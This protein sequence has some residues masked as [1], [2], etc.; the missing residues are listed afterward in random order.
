MSV[1][2]SSTTAGYPATN[3]VDGSP[4]TSWFSGGGATNSFT[5]TGQRVENLKSIRLRWNEFNPDFPH[6][7]GYGAVKITV[8][9]NGSTVGS[10]TMLGSEH[11][12]GDDVYFEFPEGT[13]G[14]VIR[15]DFSSPGNVTCGGFSEVYVVAWR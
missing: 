4:F 2:A 9:N 10:V 11:G 15:L 8:L 1:A 5:W 12:D 13:M 7:Y 14:N 3:A 6:G